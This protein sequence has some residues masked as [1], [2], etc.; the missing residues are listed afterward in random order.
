MHDIKVILIDDHHLIRE[1]I[2]ELLRETGNITVIA[3]AN[4]GKELFTILKKH[5]PDIIILD[6]SL[7]DISGIEIARIVS[8]E[9]PEIKI[10][11]LT[12][13]NDE[14]FV[15]SSIEAGAKGYLPKN[16]SKKELIEAINNIYAGEKYLSPSVS[17]FLLTK[18]NS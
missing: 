5:T 10:L 16:T 14:S 8:K 9:Y 11:M 2:R 3:E 4:D 12:M 13:Y 6:I 7:P 1:G 15:I 18:R 17:K